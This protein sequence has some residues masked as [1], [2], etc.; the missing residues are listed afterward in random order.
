MIELVY[1]FTCG[2]FRI[3]RNAFC[4]ADLPKALSLK[5]NDKKYSRAV[6]SVGIIVAVHRMLVRAFTTLHG[7]TTYAAEM[8]NIVQHV[9]MSLFIYGA[10]PIDLA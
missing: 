10:Y 3:P 6:N 7:H 8:S 4:S 9:V 2:S 5:R 1:V